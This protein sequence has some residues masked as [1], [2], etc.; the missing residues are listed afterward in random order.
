MSVAIVGLPRSGKTTLFNAITR[1]D[2]SVGSYGDVTA[3]PNIGI[4]KTTDPRLDRL[5][6]VFHSKRQIPAE[7][8]FVD[9]PGPPEGMPDVSIIGG[10]T[11]NYVQD[12]DVLLIVARA[13]E[14]PAVPHVE[15]SVDVFRDAET[16]LLELAVAD[17]AIV[18][19]RIGRI[20][21]GMKGPRAPERD[22]LNQE[23]QLLERL[24]AGLD[25][26]T[27]I[28][29][30]SLSQAEADQLQ[31]FQLVTAKPLMLAANV[32]ED[33][34]PEPSTVEDR[35]AEIQGFE[36][37]GV[38]VVCGKLEMELAQMEPEDESEFREALDMSE[39]ATERIAGILQRVMDM[40]TFFT[41]NEREVHAWPVVQGTTALRAAGTVHSDF[42][43]GF[44]RA[45]VVAADDLVGC[46]SLSEARKQGLLRQEGRD[47]QVKDGDVV[48]VLFSV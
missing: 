41:G 46:G 12:S 44:I 43:R 27:P 23:R 10:E 20:E 45:E 32:S 13:F 1:G 29:R 19:R 11:M 16:M 15:D 5:S 42:E 36:S 14:D 6:G 38:F 47:Y 4:A 48:N 3:R 26:G 25:A 7:M 9:V 31:G 24:G 39:S 22:A 35:L 33:E 34:I 17:A 37:A 40:I 21:E 18:R 30:M 2:A 28:H 8:T